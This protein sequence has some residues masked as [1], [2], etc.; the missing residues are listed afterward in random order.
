MADQKFI[1][2]LDAAQEV[3]ANASTGSGVCVVTLNNAETSISVSCT[4]SGLTSNLQADHIHANAAPG[5]NA[6]VL[7]GF[8]VTG[9][10]SGSFVA[11]PFA[12]TAPQVA[13][14]RAHLWYVNHAF[15]ELPWR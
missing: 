7:F 10:T 2:H 15:S 13:N 8:G 5:V 6:G 9:G 11:G 12:V 4:Y 1:A 14:M 3:P